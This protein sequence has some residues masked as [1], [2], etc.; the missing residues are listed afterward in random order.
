MLYVPALHKVQGAMLYV[1]GKFK[2]SDNI[3]FSKKWIPC[4][5]RKENLGLR[6]GT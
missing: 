3:Q 4:A 5:F 2:E 6:K 1:P